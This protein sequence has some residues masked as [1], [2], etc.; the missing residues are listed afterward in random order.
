MPL[1]DRIEL[2][3]VHSN[4]ENADTYFPEIDAKKWKEI[5]RK[6]HDADDKHA[7]AFSFITY[8]RK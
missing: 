5:D 1:A 3:R 4:F 8:I 7:H 2:T 6:T